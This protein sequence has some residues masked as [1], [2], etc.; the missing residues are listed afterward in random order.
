MSVPTFL[1]LRSRIAWMSA[2]A[3]AAATLA[4]PS[5]LAKSFDR[6]EGALVRVDEPLD[7]AARGV[8]KVRDKRNDQRF[9]VKAKKIDMD[10][11]VELWIDD[12]DD[13]DFVFVDDLE[14]S[15]DD[16]GDGLATFKF[17]ARYRANKS[18]GSLPLD[19]ETV[20][21][22]V[23]LP[24]EIRADGETLLTGR[25]PELGIPKRAKVKE[26]SELEATDDATD[27]SSEARARVKLFAKPARDDHRFEVKVTDFPDVDSAD[28]RLW[29]E[30][31]DD[32]GMLVD[33]GAFD[34]D[35]SD[36]A[37]HRFRRRT[38]KGEALPFGVESVEELFDLDMEIRNAGDD[39]L[40]F[41]GET[42]AGG[43]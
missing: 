4:A 11:D 24:V 10:R 20:E 8:V 6:G 40:Y 5:V 15:D 19:A 3:F 2:F 22:L 33:L 13:G 23:G 28:L 35:G 18:R 14:P 7:E 26:R 25:V 32:P 9:E 36:D 38:R 31:P 27:L 37:E 34:P 1:D 21:E 39:T 30:D 17:K 12:G 29:L 16:D 41:E 42:P 43:V